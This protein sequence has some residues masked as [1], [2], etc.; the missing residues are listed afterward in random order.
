MA[1]RAAGLIGVPAL[2]ATAVLGAAL[3]TLA[4][5]GLGIGNGPGGGGPLQLTD[6]TL[7]LRR[8]LNQG[9]DTVVLRYT[10]DRP[11]G[12]YLRMASLPRFDAS[13]WRNVQMRL[14]PAPSCRRSRG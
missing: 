10:T 1:W 13:G 2:V 7:D 9:A 4:L 5:P 12:L 8:N 3:P 6:P 14:D 11:G